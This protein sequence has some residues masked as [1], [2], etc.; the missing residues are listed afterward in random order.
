MI[1]AYPEYEEWLARLQLV[2]FMVGMGV[3]LAV[4]D[5]VKVAQQPRSLCLGLIGQICVIPLMALAISRLFKLDGPIALG[6]ILV[7]AMPGGSVSKVFAYLGRGNAPLSITL[8][9]VSTLATVVT[10]PV[11]L[12]LLATEYVPSDFEMPVGK[13]VLDVVLYLLVP[14]AAGM[15][16]G[17][18]WPQRQR[19]IGRWAVRLGFIP[20]LL[21]V[22]GSIAAGRIHPAE[23]GL[24]T[25]V[26][27]VLF[28]VIGQQLN[29]APFY[30][31]RLPRAD[32]MA[33]GIE[34]TM[35]N[36]NLALLLKSSLFG[37]EGPL[38]DGVLFVVL[39]Y[40]AVA[41]FAGV[42]LALNHRRLARRHERAQAAASAAGGP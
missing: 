38:A 16:V 17:R 26:A 8:T 14:L 9:A 25:P 3:T 10:V 27:I 22:I 37:A 11:T 23:Y 1:E 2:C 40:G 34:A 21:I 12:R 5:F 39:F 18:T 36:M 30:L 19:T 35:R 6:L 13:I 41:F 42:P 15:I 33:V 20:L 29:M 7:S 4:A 32:R 24:L 31:L 28:C